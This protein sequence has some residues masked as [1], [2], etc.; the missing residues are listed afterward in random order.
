[1]EKDNDMM[2]E[3]TLDQDVVDGRDVESGRRDVDWKGWIQIGLTLIGRDGGRKGWKGRW[4]RTDVGS[5]VDWKSWKG[6]WKGRQFKGLK[7]SSI[8]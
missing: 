5:V 4:I 1:M 7:A 2:L 3:W 6:Q 8:V